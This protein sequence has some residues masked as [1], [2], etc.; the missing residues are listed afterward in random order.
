MSWFR[1]GGYK[2]HSS[3]GG[4]GGSSS[5]SLRIEVSP[6]GRAGCRTSTMKLAMTGT[7]LGTHAILD[8]PT[9]SCT[10]RRPWAR[11]LSSTKKPAHSG[12]GRGGALLKAALLSG[13]IGAG[14]VQA[15]P[16]FSA[17]PAPTPI[18][19]PP[20][21]A[22]F[23]AFLSLVQLPFVVAVVLLSA[24]TAGFLHACQFTWCLHRLVEVAIKVVAPLLLALGAW[25]PLAFK[26]PRTDP[27]GVALLA[28]LRE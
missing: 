21:L 11:A 26:P 28:C 6:S 19:P 25:A 7:A 14:S 23:D 18:P 24:T 20:L 10:S 22:G 3:Y 15:A 9:L 12:Y 4:G 16:D 2:S 5:S 13:L 27:L 1:R 17:S 8:Y